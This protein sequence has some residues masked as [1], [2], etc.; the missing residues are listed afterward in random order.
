MADPT[1]A[2]R[3]YQTATTAQLSEERDGDE[4]GGGER[5]MRAALQ[6]EDISCCHVVQSQKA[7]VRWTEERHK[8][9]ERSELGILD[10]RT[11]MARTSP[12][13]RRQ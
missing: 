13:A 4:G 1:H 2:A 6:G 11:V 8:A 3:T 12:N 5:A 7:A 10:G 9:E